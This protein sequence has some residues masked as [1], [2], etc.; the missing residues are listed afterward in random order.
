LRLQ[1][2]T[3]LWD[4]HPPFQIDGNFGATAGIAE[5]LL[6]SHAGVIHVLPALPRAWPA[7]SVDGLRARGGFTV[8]STWRAGA[9]TEVRIAADHATTARVKSASLTGRVR[10]VDG[11]GRS[12]RWTRDTTDTIHFQT[13]AKTAY[14]LTPA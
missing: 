3:N 2:L 9:A 8:G 10:V 1:T 7:G 5:M 11:R 12:V 6:Q 4:T 14:T 13:R